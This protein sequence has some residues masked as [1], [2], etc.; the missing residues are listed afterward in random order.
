MLRIL[1]AIIFCI[2]VGLVIATPYHQH[3]SSSSY[4]FV[5]AGDADK[6]DSDFLAVIDVRPNSS[7]YGRIVT[8]LPVGVSGT[9]AHHTEHEMPAGGIL[10]AN[11]FDAGK[12][13]KFDLTKPETPRLLGSFGAAGAYT[14]PHSF[15]RLPD[16]NVL[17]TF[18]TRGEGNKE[19]GALVELDPE[20]RML[21]SASAADPKVAAFIRPYSLAVVPQIDRV[22]TTSADMYEKDISR[23]VQVWRLSDF[24]LLKT[25]VLPSGPRGTE[26]I[27]SA[28]PR[29]LLDGRTVLVSTFHCGLYK[30]VGLEGMNPSAQMVYSFPFEGDKECALPVVAG[31]FWVQTVPLEHALVS[32]DMSNP[33]KPVEISRL[34]LGARDWP[35]WI[36]LEPNGER[37][38][39]TG[40]DDLTYRVL[41]A[42]V[43]RESGKLSLDEAFREEGSNRPGFSFD[44]EQWPHGKT[45]KA[46]PHGAVFSRL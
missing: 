28:E 15:V 13:F 7:R 43:N 36:S 44:R 14:Y 20:G 21:R 25:I 41:I 18:Q 46:I 27:N 8:T 24:T 9:M 31:R 45:G 37:I 12:T 17:A 35:H 4:L 39:I 34:V 22:V 6:R 26:G 29:V 3:N 40:Y 2:S 30:M 33:D 5:W 10:F 19:A 1:L 32:L 11:G 42:K 38:V 16:G 23:V